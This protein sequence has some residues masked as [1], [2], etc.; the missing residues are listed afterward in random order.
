MNGVAK[1]KDSTAW[2]FQAETLPFSDKTP[3]P[4]GLVDMITLS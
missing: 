2:R 1:P 3:Q 4:S